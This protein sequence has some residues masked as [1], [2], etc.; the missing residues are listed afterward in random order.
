MAN[1]TVLYGF[2]NLGDIYNNT[3]TNELI[4]VVTD[5]IEESRVA[6]NDEI[7]AVQSL[8]VEP[9]TKF[10]ERFKVASGARLQP[11]DENGRARVVKPSGYFDVAYPIKKA[12]IAEGNTF[13]AGVLQT[14]ADVQATAAE[15]FIADNNWM[16]DQ[17]LAAMYNNAD[18]TYVDEKNGSLTI[19]P[20]ANN[21]TQVY[22]TNTAADTGT[23]QNNLL[24]TTDAIADATNPLVTAARQLRKFPGDRRRAISLVPSNLIDDV[25]NLAGFLDS[26]DP[27]VR[28]G[29][30]TDVA[31]GGPGVPFPGVLRG[32]DKTSRTWIVEWE[33]LQDDRI[34]V[35]PIGGARPIARREYDN[36][37]LQGF[38]LIGERNDVP[39]YERQYGRWAGFGAR[40][41]S[42][43]VGI[44][45]GS[46]S[47]TI[48][49]GFN[50]ASMG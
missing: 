46:A 11:L 19:K 6:H 38:V 48:P 31:A 24:G 25:M 23:I 3:V 10:Q 28:V 33:R 41:R 15:M 42:A 18:W 12:G 17:V 1:N 16:M 37:R 29:A 20:I 45:V 26:P 30:N 21:D 43:L 49:T 32:Y 27:E 35:L 22:A 34:F 44:Q 47:W 5:A 2:R 50:P 4:P 7:Q 36:P 39:Y 13:E 8:L 14:V 9:T 40:D